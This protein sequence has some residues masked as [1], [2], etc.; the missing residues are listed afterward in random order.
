MHG[1]VQSALHSAAIRLTSMDRADPAM[2]ESIRNEIDAAICELDAPGGS[3]ISLSATLDDIANLWSGV[4]AI[5]WSLTPAAEDL[6]DTHPLTSQCVG[7]IAREAVNNAIRHGHATEIMCDVS[8]DGSAALIVVS[9]SGAGF[10]Q[11]ARG[12]GMAMYDHLCKEWTLA[13]R[14][15]GAVLTAVIPFAAHTPV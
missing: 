2:I 4:C 8:T 1:R 14:S 3:E 12:L 10:N 5:E 13:S 15:S 7:E 11:D 9:D 6:L